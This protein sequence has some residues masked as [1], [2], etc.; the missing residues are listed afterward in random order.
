M[1]ILQS[2]DMLFRANAIAAAEAADIFRYPH[3]EQKRDILYN[4]AA[5]FLKLSDEQI[6][7]HHQH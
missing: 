2:A 1:K 5:R 4:N 6:A 7:A 3:S